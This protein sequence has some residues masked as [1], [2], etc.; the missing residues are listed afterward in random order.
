MSPISIFQIDK[1]YYRGNFGIPHSHQIL[2]EMGRS[3]SIYHFHY[4]FEKQEDFDQ[5]Q[6]AFASEFKAHPIRQ[7]PNQFTTTRQILKW[8]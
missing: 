4:F 1:T 3:A 8:V 7:F 5:Y 6:Q 2:K